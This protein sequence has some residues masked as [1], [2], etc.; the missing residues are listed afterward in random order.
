P[1]TGRTIE[2]ETHPIRIGSV[3]DIA[4]VVRD[5]AVSRYH[6]EAHKKA[7]EYVI[8]DCNSTNGTFVGSLRVKEATIRHRGEISIG[9]SSL[10]FE[11]MDTEVVVEPAG[12][13]R[14]D[15]MVGRSVQM[16]EIYTVIERVAPTELTILVTGETGTGKEL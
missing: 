3:D 11:P 7:G 15:E 4:L 2:T 6:L 16:R 8:V 5:P 14:C 9:D 10:L 12:A 13:E 1:A